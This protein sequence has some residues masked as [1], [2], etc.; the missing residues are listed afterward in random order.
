MERLIFFMNDLGPTIGHRAIMTMQLGDQ[1]LSASE[2]SDA[3]LAR[4]S[5]NGFGD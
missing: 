4:G 2:D 3:Q 1:M 5:S